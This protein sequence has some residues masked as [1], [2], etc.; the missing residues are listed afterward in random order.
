MTQPSVLDLCVFISDLKAV[1]CCYT[2]GK[3]FDTD[4]MD[5]VGKKEKMVKPLVKIIWS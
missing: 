3:K 1:Q 2:A 5:I 4:V